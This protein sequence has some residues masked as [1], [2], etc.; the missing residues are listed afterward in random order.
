MRVCDKH[1]ERRAV[2]TVHIQ[3]D[4]SFVDV[5]AE[6]KTDVLMLLAAQPEPEPPPAEIPSIVEV[7]P[8]KR[9]FFSRGN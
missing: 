5:C 4:D 3:A 1:R 7:R 2:D 9:G 8:P 6:C